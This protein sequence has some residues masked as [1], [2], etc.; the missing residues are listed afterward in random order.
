MDILNID[1]KSLY[2]YIIDAYTY[3][4]GEQ[5]RS[6]IADRVNKTRVMYYYNVNALSGYFQAIKS[7]KARK[8][9]YQF[10]ERIGF[11]LKKYG[12]KEEL[13]F[14]NFRL[15]QEDLEDCDCLISF[16]LAFHQ[17]DDSYSSIRFFKKDSANDIARNR[18]RKI[19]AL[20]YLLREEQITITDENLDDFMKTEKYQELLNIINEY[21]KIYDELLEEYH[22]DLE[23]LKPVKKYIEEEN[24]R[25]YKISQEKMQELYQIVI[26]G[27]PTE[28]KQTIIQ[29]PM[30][31]IMLKIM[32]NSLYNA[33][34]MEFFSKENLAILKD[35][36]TSI[37]DKRRIVKFQTKY[38]QAI[39]LLKEDI[40]INTEEDAK[41]YIEFLEQDSIKKYLP[42]IK[43]VDTLS[44]LRKQKC[45]EALKEYIITRNDFLKIFKEFDE[46]PS[47]I[48][49]IYH[50]IEEEVVCANNGYENGEFIPFICYTI[51]N[52]NITFLFR[53]LMHEF[54]HI[55]DMS[56]HGTG[57]E[58]NSD[59]I[60]L[61]LKG[62][63]N[64]EERRYVFLNETIN[65][66]Y[67]IKATDYL[68][69]KGIY[70]ME[71]K[72]LTNKEEQYYGTSPVL[73]DLVTPLVEKYTEI[74]TLAKIKNEREILIKRIGEE[75]FEKLVDV[76]NRVGSLVKAGLNYRLFINSSHPMII[77]YY[78]LLNKSKEIYEKID[79]YYK[80]YTEKHS[81][82]SS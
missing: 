31:T 54:G 24:E 77:E 67:R 59:F 10:L 63:Y 45:E 37:Y 7:V 26:E 2:P 40:V 68:Y 69:S 11:D 62:N 82:L 36:Y 70:L 1:F 8:C 53:L 19:K 4:Y 47:A 13:T 28:I 38:L 51:R 9:V 18:F 71:E 80:N 17:D 46:N 44:T 41:N 48:D 56:E 14:Y 65:E 6:I 55:I 43:F 58:E 64:S 23:Y 34:N 42:P 32:S 33:F 30:K 72:E 73:I 27:L 60:D 5:Y 22:K 75:N 29:E 76:I 16:Y 35:K 39:G 49:Y 57:F 66:I 61:G 81:I 79:L 21:N 52:R 15:N 3:A 78:Q 25:L 74:V 20:N 50:I 12:K